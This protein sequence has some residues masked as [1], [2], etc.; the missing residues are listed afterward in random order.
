MSTPATM[1]HAAKRY[2]PN[3]GWI[4]SFGASSSARSGVYLY[5]A[6]VY[7]LPQAHEHHRQSERAAY[8]LAETQPLS[9]RALRTVAVAGAENEAG[10]VAEDAV[11]YV[12]V[13][14]DRVRIVPLAVQDQANAED[15]GD[16]KDSAERGERAQVK[17]SCQV[18]WHDAA[19]GSAWSKPASTLILHRTTHM[20]IQTNPRR[21]R[22][23]IIQQDTKQGGTTRVR[24]KRV[25]YEISVPASS[26]VTLPGN[27]F[28]SESVA[29]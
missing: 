29:A 8:A 17:V 28:R 15:G 13:F 16:D 11:V 21:E 19:R 26:A 9:E 7:G 20:I 5:V 25:F 23:H 14:D 1:S 4:H 6:R 27:L 24:R 10:G 2:L 22:D 18:E 3:E 12:R